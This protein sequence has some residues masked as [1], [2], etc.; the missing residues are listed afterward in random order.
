MAMM[1][2]LPELQE[3]LKS[4]GLIYSVRRFRY[5]PSIKVVF[6]PGVGA[7]SR[8]LVDTPGVTKEA[9]KPYYEESGFD[10]LEAW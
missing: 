9:L 3:H 1:H 5:D 6:I 8:R 2:F 4:R 10:T 7:C